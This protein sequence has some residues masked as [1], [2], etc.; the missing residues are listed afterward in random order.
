[1]ALDALAFQMINGLASA[2]GLFFVAAGLSIIFGVTRIVNMAHGAFYM[3]G[4]YLAVTLADRLPGPL[5]YWGGLLLAALA[6]GL[7]G[8]AVEV[9]LLRRIYH[10]PEL[11]QLVAT[12]ALALILN[13]AA[14]WLWG[15]EDLL[16]PRAPGL[17]GSVELIGR[18]LPEYDVFLAFAGPAVLLALHLLMK[19]TRFGR[20][21]RAATQDR[22]MVAA[23]GIN[24]ALLFTAVF[25]LGAFLAG[26][27]GALQTAREPAN[28][29]LDLAVLGDAFVVVVIGGMGS[30]PGAYLAAVLVA[31]VKALCIALGTV[32]IAGLAFNMSKLTL[33]AEFLV[34]ALVLVLRPQG[35]FGRPQAAAARAAASEAPL[36]PMGGTGRAL[37][38]AALA[39]ALAVPALATVWAYAPVLALDMLIAVTFAASLHLLMGPGG[40]ASFGHAAYFGLGAY[41]TALAATGLGL[42]TLPAFAVGILAAGAG[43][44]LFGWFCVRLE[45]VYLAML[46]LAFAQIVWSVVFQW[47]EVTGGSNGLIGIW[48]DWPFDSRAGLYLAA[49]AVT[50][51]GLYL[52]RRLIF[53]PFGHA[54]RAGRDARMRAE[55]S[56]IDVARI[57]WLAFTASGMLAGAAGGLYAFAKGSISPETLAVGRSIDA[58]VMVL[59]GGLASPAGPVL[60]AGAF[61]L[62]QDTVMRE[63]DY[64]RA[65]LGALI[66]ALVLLFPGGIAGGL[67]RLFAGGR[68]DG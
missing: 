39:V 26:L 49:L 67:S 41:G 58:L 6:V 48:P 22:E 20:T 16:G 3:L 46:T 7:L 38:L 2:S 31:L 62:L 33:V 68:A 10:V 34:M 40:M 18:R 61:T 17:K 12:F 13:D 55:A 30:I 28:L 32:E 64:W 14:L 37:A 8:A 29:N 44:L 21:V 4:L 60:G 19:R 54:L 63:T 53:A 50:V 1:M 15:P 51:A 66:L 57:R 24:E 59:L 52:I 42:P 27:G 11:Y 56:G 35:L 43:A 9:L 5:G 45:G 47:E 36:R 23:L 65:L 25:A